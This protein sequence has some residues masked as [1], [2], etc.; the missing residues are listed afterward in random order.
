VLRADA[1]GGAAADRRGVKCQEGCL[2]RCGFVLNGLFY[3]RCR[4]RMD[5]FGFVSLSSTFLHFV[6]RC[7]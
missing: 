7:P 5:E 2:R 3:A 6:E 4:F 1:D